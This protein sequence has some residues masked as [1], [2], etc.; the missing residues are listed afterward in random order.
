MNLIVE[1]LI[2]LAI[3]MG[4]NDDTLMK[5]KPIKGKNSLFKGI[6]FTL[7]K[8]IFF[9]TTTTVAAYYLGMTF[10]TNNELIDITG[11]N[12]YSS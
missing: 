4:A 10:L 5:I 1:S 7:F 8:I 9:T 2:A 11:A 6:V 12:N 3:G